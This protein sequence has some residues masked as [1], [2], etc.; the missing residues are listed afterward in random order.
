LIRLSDLWLINVPVKNKNSGK[1]HS[2]EIKDKN[3]FRCLQNATKTSYLMSGNKL[4]HRL[5]FLA[6]G[7]RF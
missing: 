7:W 3:D 6:T 4:S 2:V 5:F 1:K